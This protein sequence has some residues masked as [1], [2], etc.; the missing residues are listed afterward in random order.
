MPA[1]RETMSRNTTAALW[2]INRLELIQYHEIG[3][4]MITLC[5]LANE[6]LPKPLRSR[7]ISADYCEKENRRDVLRGRMRVSLINANT[8]ERREEG[9]QPWIWQQTRLLPVDMP[10]NDVIKH[11]SSIH[12]VF[13]CRCSAEH[14]WHIFAC[15]PHAWTHELGS[16]IDSIYTINCKWRICLRIFKNSGTRLIHW[17]V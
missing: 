6:I 13:Y 1:Y 2:H 3:R 10:E 9:R 4:V 11:V 12:S 17:V 15:M 16:I 5:L 14:C 8:T 7:V